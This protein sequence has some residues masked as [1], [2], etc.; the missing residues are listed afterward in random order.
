MLE[1]R[2]KKFNIE[3]FKNLVFDFIDK[4]NLK[5]ISFYPD[6][7]KI[8]LFSHYQLH[9]L[10]PNRSANNQDGFCWAWKK[11]FKKVRRISFELY[12]RDN[13]NSIIIFI[14]LNKKKIILNKITGNKISESQV[15]ELIKNNFEIKEDFVIKNFLVFLKKYILKILT[16]LI[17]AVFAGVV[18][19]LIVHFF[20]KGGL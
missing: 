20:E 6:P 12:S 13:S 14:D 9:H 15:E 2:F 16:G 11:Q 10:A 19:K 5:I 18:I 4:Y 3:Y 8:H 1:K 7:D 17:V